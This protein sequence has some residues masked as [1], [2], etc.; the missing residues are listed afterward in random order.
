MGRSASQGSSKEGTSS[1]SKRERVRQRLDQ[2]T[3]SARSADLS[4]R[5]RQWIDQVTESEREARSADLRTRARPQTRSER[6]A[7]LAD[8]CTSNDST[9]NRPGVARESKLDD[10]G[11]KGS[12]N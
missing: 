6:E 12:D 2:E 3:E 9:M 11:N 1:A 5:A 8:L 7:R 4:T 10:L